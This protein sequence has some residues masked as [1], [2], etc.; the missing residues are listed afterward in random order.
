MGM[1]D[2]F[3][4]RR[5]EGLGVGQTGHAPSLDLPSL[6]M[7]TPNPSRVREGSK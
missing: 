7:L 4:S 6:D 2:M 1:D 5:R 3:P